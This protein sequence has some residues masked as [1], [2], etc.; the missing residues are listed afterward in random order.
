MKRLAA[1]AWAGL[2][3]GPARAGLAFFSL[4][5]GLFAVSVLLA[6]LDALQRQARNLVDAFGADAFV[7][8]RSAEPA[9]SR[10]H[11][12][13]F[14][15]NL[16]DVARVAGVKAL[17]AI[18]GADF[19]VATTDAEWARVRSG[20]FVAGRALDDL[21]VRQGA[22]CAVAPAGLCRR[23]GWRVGETISIGPEPY[24]RALAGTPYT[25]LPGQFELTR[26]WLDASLR[27]SALEQVELLRR[28]HLRQLPFQ[29]AHYDTL[30]TIMLAAPTTHFVELSQAILYRGAGIGVVWKPFLALALIG[31]ALFALALTRFRRTISQMA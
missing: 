30:Q 29:A 31:S 7:L 6:T 5:L 26:F 27:I 18:A 23:L 22:R 3:T 11:V 8:T 4:A 19:S 15:A 16:G 2:R 20:R 1:D 25:A 28:I 9:W 12:D 17:P 14:R 24:R 21:D 13:F 10:R